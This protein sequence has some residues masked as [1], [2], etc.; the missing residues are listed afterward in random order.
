MLVNLCLPISIATTTTA[1]ASLLPELLELAHHLQSQHICHLDRDERVVLEVDE[2]HDTPVEEGHD[3]L[4]QLLP[5]PTQVV[6][7][8]VTFPDL[9]CGVFFMLLFVHVALEEQ[10]GVE[11]DA[12]DGSLGTDI[13]LQL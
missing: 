9:I 6:D 3:P 7:P 11:V 13:S 1:G 4:E 5:L 2:L 10:V 12:F 8:D